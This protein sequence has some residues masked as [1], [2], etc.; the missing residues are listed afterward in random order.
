MQKFNACYVWHSWMAVW[1]NTWWEFAFVTRFLQSLSSVSMHWN[2]WIKSVYGG[3]CVAYQSFA[4]KDE[5]G[6]AIWLLTTG[7]FSTF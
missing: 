1:V 5:S 2:I 4:T 7:C 6:H 3:S